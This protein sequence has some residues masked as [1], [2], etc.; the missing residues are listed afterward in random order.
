MYLTLCLLVVHGK[1]EPLQVSLEG[2]ARQLALGDAVLS[3]IHLDPQVLLVFLQTS[4]VSLSYSKE[5][6]LL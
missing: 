5:Y 4:L 3:I 6:W 2:S 1:F